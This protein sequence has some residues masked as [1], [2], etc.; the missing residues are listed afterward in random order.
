[1]VVNLIGNFVKFLNK[2]GFVIDV[3]ELMLGSDS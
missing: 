3:G 2:I 1:M